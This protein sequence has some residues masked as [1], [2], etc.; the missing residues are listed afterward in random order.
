MPNT[1]ARTALNARLGG[2]ASALHRPANRINTPAALRGR[3]ACR[4][5][6]F[7]LQLFPEQVSAIAGV[8]RRNHDPFKETP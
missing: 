6:D 8:L 5:N 4:S 1:R 3:V 2:D 7:S